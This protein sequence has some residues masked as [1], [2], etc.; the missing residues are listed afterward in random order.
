MPEENQQPVQTLMRSLSDRVEDLEKKPFHTCPAC[1]QEWNRLRTCHYIDDHKQNATSDLC[2]VCAETLV[3]WDWLVYTMPLP[4]AF[5]SYTK[6]VGPRKVKVG[7]KE[8]D[9][10]DRPQ[11]A[12]VI[13]EVNGMEYVARSDGTGRPIRFKNKNS[14]EVQTADNIY[15]LRSKLLHTVGW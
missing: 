1:Q 6:W 4:A 14:E 9:I 2:V 12:Y 11:N 10:I 15:Q 7:P 3:N 5:L 13:V 8:D